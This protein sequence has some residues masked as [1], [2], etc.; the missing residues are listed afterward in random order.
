[1][2][3]VGYILS[4]ALYTAQNVTAQGIIM[5]RKIAFITGASRGIGKQATLALASKGFDVVITARTMEEGEEH[6]RGSD[7]SDTSPLEGSLMTTAREVEALGQRALAIRLDLLDTHSIE[8]AFS[9]AIAQW[10]HID[11]L[12]NNGIYQGPGVMKEVLE[13][14]P[15]M[16]QNIFQ[17]NIFS[18]LL[19]T[20]L[21]LRHMLERGNG[22]IINMVSGSGMMDPPA[23]ASEGGWGWAYSASKAAFMRMAGVLKVEHPDS[24]L[25]FFNVEPGF[26]ITEIMKKKGMIEDYA[27]KF[28]GAPPTVPAAVVAWLA[29]S[30]EASELNG[31]TISAQRHC[32]KY[33]LV[34]EW[35][36]AKP[37]QH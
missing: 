20:Q 3:P 5:P 18:Q 21:A 2:Q 30:P 19:L 16:M 11:V 6:E 13:L 25:N 17:G 37:K 8:R 26:V 12:F 15:A 31:T 33:Q 32:L 27:K 28:G 29:T 23:R 34:P 35:Q 22:T 7:Q 9:E 4:I 10:G 24:K 1:L 36:P 14:T